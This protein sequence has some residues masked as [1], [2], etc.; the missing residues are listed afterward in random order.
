MASITS[1]QLKNGDKRYSFQ[2]Y[3]GLD[4]QT[5][6]PKH[7]F[8]RGFKTKKQATLEASR[9]ELAIS[10]GDLKKENNILFKTVYEEWYQSYINT[11]RVSTYAR[12]GNMFVNHILPF[13]G[14][15]RI[16]TITVQQVQKAVNQWVVEAPNNYKKWFQYMARVFEFALKHGYMHGDNPAKL[17]TMPKP[18]EQW[19]KKPENFWTKEELQQF[20]SYID[21]V[22]ELEKYTLF[23]VLA[24]T[25]L[26]RDEMLALTWNDINFSQAT[27]TVNKTLAQGIG[28]KLII[29]PPKTKAGNRTIKLDPVTLSYLKRWRARQKREYLVLGFNTLKR[30]QLIFANSKNKFKSENTPSKWL[31]KI[32][33]AHHLKRITIHG[34]RHSHT[35]FL[36]ESGVPLKEVQTRLGHDDVQTTLNVYAHVTEKQENEAVQKLVSFL[37]F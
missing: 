14:N 13:F 1:Y 29:N 32:V 23:R 4:P 24:F 36:L 9:L 26:R 37:N 11:V 22:E 17:I 33:K 31:N 12:V 28:G 34:F 19:K 27:L 3:A 7:L 6:K 20:F 18:K 2:I 30:G 25:G 15:K 8:R 16:R 10:Q 21:P 5:G 35:S